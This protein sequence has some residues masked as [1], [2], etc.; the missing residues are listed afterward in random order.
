M[1]FLADECFVGQVVRQLRLQG[2]D[3]AWIREDAPGLSDEEVLDRSHAELRILL[4]HDWDFGELAVRREKPATGIV[5]VAAS[6]LVG[7][8]RDAAIAVTL[9]L[10]EQGDALKDNLT[11]LE[12]GRMRHRNLARSAN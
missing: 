2:C 1:R 6:A 12:A 11:I 3:V 8:D 4:T 7:G 5:I 9:R 10:I